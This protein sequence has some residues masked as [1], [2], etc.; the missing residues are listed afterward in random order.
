MRSYRLRSDLQR[1]VI[2][3]FALPL[4]IMPGKLPSPRPGFTVAYTAGEDDD[5]DTYTL[6]VVVSHELVAPIL[7]EAFELLPEHV[8]PIIEIGSRDAYR[9]VDTYLGEDLIGY[10]DFRRTWD[11][12]EP[13]LL[14]DV[15][16]GAGANSEDPFVEVFMDQWKGIS[17]HVPPSMREQAE[18]LLRRF[19][20]EEVTQS[21]TQPED[22]AQQA[23]SEVRPVLE[24]VDDYS[25]DIDEVLLQLRSEWN[26][27]LDV[28]P[29]SNMDGSGRH[30]GHTLW[31]AVV[32]VQDQSEEA[33]TG[34]YAE[35]WATAASIDEVQQL[36]REAID[37]TGRW[38]FH[39][40]YILDR[41]PFDDRPDELGALTPRREKAEIHILQIDPWGPAAPPEPS[42]G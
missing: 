37:K 20:L 6:H 38:R 36:M 14:E 8:C 34:G 25:P 1:A 9:A 28:D 35:V 3:G 2:D 42:R 23:E 27:L 12:F 32:I 22:D 40:V 13:L 30:L 29:Q 21:W 18:Q 11:R 19:G 5:P 24:I 15:S 31:H 7:H 26:L 41:V 33:L 4:G 39:D 10:H 16:I 17:I